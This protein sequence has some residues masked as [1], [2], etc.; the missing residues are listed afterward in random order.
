MAHIDKIVEAILNGVNQA[1]LGAN[2]HLRNECNN[3]SNVYTLPQAVIN[4]IELNLNYALADASSECEL[5]EM[6]YTKFYAFL[7]D[8]AKQSA[9]IITST[10]VSELT[11]ETIGDDNKGLKIWTA[12]YEGKGAEY[13]KL[14]TYTSRKIYSE[15]ITLSETILN[16]QGSVQTEPLVSAIC[17]VVDSD[18]LMQP[19]IEL[20][21]SDNGH[22][23]RERVM[24]KLSMA[25][26]P[27]I[28][29]LVRDEN[30]RNKRLA[31]TADVIV[32]AKGLEKIP[33]ECIHSMRLKISFPSVPVNV[34]TEN[35]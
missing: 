18:L 30:F 9:K 3:K 13:R 16:E 15:L 4:S 6:D 12:L 7:K 27:F 8:A 23:N 25:L 35:K 33:S 28:E 1:Q 29:Q 31:T 10:I 2:K 5:Y 32:D 19:D 17:S 21:F 34:N 26:S 24:N 22:E 11:P 20:M 14:I